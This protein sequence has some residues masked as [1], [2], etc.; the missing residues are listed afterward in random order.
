MSQRTVAEIN[1]HIL[2]LPPVQPRAFSIHIELPVSECQSLGLQSLHNSSQSD[3]LDP[4]EVGV[5]RE[6]QP[7]SPTADM[8][9]RFEHS[10]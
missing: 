2:T 6:R 10:R 8:I 9:A 5:K 3:N 1:Q 7:E 4:I